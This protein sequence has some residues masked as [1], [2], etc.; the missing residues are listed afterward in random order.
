MNK[1]SLYWYTLSSAHGMPS[2]LNNRFLN[3]G[4]HNS[5][6]HYRVHQKSEF[7]DSSNSVQLTIELQE[8]LVK[9]LASSPTISPSH[10]LRDLKFK[11]VSYSYTYWI[12][13]EKSVKAYR[14]TLLK[15]YIH[16]TCNHQNPTYQA[17]SI[18]AINR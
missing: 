13:A 6:A 5:F 16:G 7:D 14:N 10:L 2:D 9:V 18:Y 12:K 15:K 11:Y 17:D 8:S 1:I 4:V 3:F